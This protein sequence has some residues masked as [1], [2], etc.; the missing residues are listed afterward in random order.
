MAAT[1][2]GTVKKQEIVIS[3]ERTYWTWKAWSEMNDV[4]L[5]DAQKGSQRFKESKATRLWFDAR[6]SWVLIFSIET[7]KR[8]HHASV[9]GACSLFGKGSRQH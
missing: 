6:G 8:M 3:M 5:W 9:V 1:I 2:E 7:T 4:W